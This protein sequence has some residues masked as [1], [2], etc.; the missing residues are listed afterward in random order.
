MYIYWPSQY[1]KRFTMNIKN[2]VTKQY[3][4]IVNRAVD[5]LD[6]LEVPPEGWIRTVRTALGMTGIQL[7]DR[8]GVSRGRAYRIE[9]DEVAGNVTLKTMHSTAE[10]MG[11]KFIYAIVPETD[12]ESFVHEK[13]FKRAIYDVSQAYKHMA[14]EEQ[15]ISNK[16]L[17]DEVLRVTSQIEQKDISSVWEKKYSQLI[18]SNNDPIYLYIR[19]TITSENKNTTKKYKWR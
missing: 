4:T 13:A 16:E 6:K 9:K 1:T 19:K 11:C 3:R 15:K 12:V 7:A 8:L 18:D 14:F 17:R 10:A 2:V 5:K